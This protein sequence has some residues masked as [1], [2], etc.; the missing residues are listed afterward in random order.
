MQIYFDNAA[1]SFPKPEEVYATVDHILR[2]VGANPGRSGHRMA[3]EASRF[4]YET[5]VSAASFFNVPDEKNV[6]FTYNATDALNIGIKGL[7]KPGDHVITSSMEHNSVIRPLHKLSKKGIPYTV[8]KCSKLGELDPKDIEN[9]INKE[10]KLIVLTHASNI[11]GTVFDI[12][13]VGSIAKKHGI[14]FM[15]DAA[16]TA[17][18]LDID[19]RRMNIDMLACSGHKSLFGL[20]G[21]G[22]LYVK[23]GIDL[24]TIKEGGTG[25]HSE[26]PD[27]PDEMPD[28][29]E[30]G[31]LNTPGIAGL[32][33]GIRFIMSKTLENIRSK[34]VEL[35]THLL[36]ELR[37]IDDVTLYGVC[38]PS[39]QVNVVS[40]NIKGM[41]CSQVG[42]SLDSEHNIMVRVGLHCS[43]IG[44]KTLETFPQ[45]T[46]RVS[47]G[48]FNTHEEIDYFIKSINEIIK[49]G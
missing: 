33:A 1:T 17:G 12:E 14:V 47:L 24:D 9:A 30:S 26:A 11:C 40:F 3:I 8:V 29:Y 7:L 35:L 6:I 32:G 20:Q 18:V 43:P 31:T 42:Y 16:Q 4:I 22:I 19:V 15:V 2:E 28:K 25:S 27:Q 36:D 39:R 49:K 41:E 44:H 48:Y 23:D 10:T 37:K 13:A 5:R 38:D 34:E 45:G 46:V 21:T